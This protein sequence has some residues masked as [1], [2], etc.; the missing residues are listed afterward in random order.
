MPDNE[1]VLKKV[2]DAQKYISGL[3]GAV[4]AHALAFSQMVV[5]KYSEK[6]LASQILNSCIT[7]WHEKPAFYSQLCDAF[8]LKMRKKRVA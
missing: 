8:N 2:A 4:T 3:D 5:N 1:E 6:D 7:D